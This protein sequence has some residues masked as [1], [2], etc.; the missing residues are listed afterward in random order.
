MWYVTTQMVDLR[1]AESFI[2]SQRALIEVDQ[3]MWHL[4]YIAVLTTLHLMAQDLW[5]I[6]VIQI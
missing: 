5:I 4:I 6:E 1:V 3:A 2:V